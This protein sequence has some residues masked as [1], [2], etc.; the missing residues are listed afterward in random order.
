MYYN[1]HLKNKNKNLD[2][3]K[4]NNY[5]VEVLCLSCFNG[6]LL[7]LSAFGNHLN[8]ILFKFV[9]LQPTFNATRLPIVFV[10][11]LGMLSENCFSELNDFSQLTLVG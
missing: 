5:F 1:V 6:R 2:D 4:I 11:A 7:I 10:C 8:K 9:S 3:E